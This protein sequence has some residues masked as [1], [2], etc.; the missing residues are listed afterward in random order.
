HFM[1]EA[2][3]RGQK[4]VVVSPDY[5]D[6]TKFAD[7][8]LPAQAGTDAA[9]AMAMGHVILREFYVERQVPRF[10]DYAR[11]FTDLP[12]LV[13]LRP[14]GDGG[15]YVGDRFLH[16]ADLSA[17]ELAGA[18]GQE[19]AAWKT[20]VWD[21]ATDG[22]AVPNG[23]L[24]FRHE[25]AAAGP[26][27][28]NLDLG[29]IQPALT[30]LGRHDELVRVK[31]PRFDQGPTEGGAVLERGVPAR[32]VGGQLVTTVYDLLLAQY[33]VS[34]DGLPGT[35]PSGYEDAAEPYT[36]AWQES[37]TSVVADRAIRVAREFARNAERSGGRSMIAMGAG[38]NHWY[39]SDQ[40]Y[41]SFLTLLQLCGCEG[42]NGG[43][44][45]HYVGQ[46]KVRPL[47]GWSTIAMAS[48]WVRATRQQAGTPFWYLATDQWRYE[49]VDAGE[50]ASPLGE[51]LFAGRQFVDCNAQ[52][53]RLGWLPTNPTFDRNPLDL[54]AEAEA[55]GVPPADHVVAELQAGRLGWACEDP[56]AAENFPRVVTVWR[57]NLLTS[58]GKGHEYFLKHLL[59]S[60]THAVRAEESPPGARPRDVRWRDEAPEGKVD[61]MVTADFR[62]TGTCLFSDIVLPA[63]TWYEKHDL[64][65][66]DLHPFVNSFSPAIAPPWEARTDW[67]TFGALARRFSEL[68]GKHLGVRRDLLAVP[69]LHDSP[70]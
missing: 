33:G 61:L 4:V 38:T 68:A 56:D 59:G 31:L 55:A 53:A 70:D 8:W 13:T 22:P 10:L 11:R 37:I 16:A 50:L 46:E 41:R 6:H 52:A 62:M 49:V 5:A 14:H 44:W 7:D 12:C 69:L 45:A 30:M 58:S 42:V 47:T 2:R 1:V 17:E 24:G 9:L 26:R 66:T 15:A 34:R 48:D 51:G 25:T 65:T 40:I 27:R 19:Q 32:R 28:W 43:G 18:A 29:L 60:K 39:H 3:Y 54:V 67:D 23:S 20:V 21:E 57:A 63:A 35:W 64:S 36:P